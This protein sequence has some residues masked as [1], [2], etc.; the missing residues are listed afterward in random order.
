MSME[1][2]AQHGY[3]V[4]INEDWFKA[5]LKDL[6]NPNI[7]NKFLEELADAFEG[8]DLDEESLRDYLIDDCYDI[9][10][11]MNYS[12]DY[13]DYK[14]VFEG[15]KDPDYSPDMLACWLGQ[16]NNNAFKPDYISEESLIKHAYEAM[17]YIPEGFDVRKYI[18]KYNQASTC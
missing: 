3:A 4:L 18:V 9:D 13:F 10:V 7:K 11:T 17:P 6:N 2:T 1:T 14:C 5:V 15:Q 12:D 8:E 16:D